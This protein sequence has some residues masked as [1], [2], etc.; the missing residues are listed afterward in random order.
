MQTSINPTPLTFGKLLGRAIS[1]YPTHRAILLRTAAIFYL[2]AAALSFL[3]AE[4]LATSFLLSLVFWPVDGIVSLSLITHCIDSLHGRPL[5]ISPA[6][7]RGLRRL[8]AYMG[9]SVA[10]LVVLSGVAFILAAPVWIGLLYSG[11]SLA[12]ILDAFSTPANPDQ[13]DIV[14]RVLGSALWGG[15]GLC[16]SGL[17]IPAV[18]FYLSTR[19]RFAE[20]ALMTEGTGPLESL[21]RSWS[22]SR[23]FVLRTLG[24]LLLIVIVMGLVGGVIG[25]ALN[26]AVDALAPTTDQSRMIGFSLAFSRLLSI[27]VMPFYVTAI[28]LYYFDLRVRKEKYNFGVVQE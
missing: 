19:W 13:V 23:G 2:P 22:L 6:V 16:L 9:L 24:Y 4:D 8:P 28:V 12:E 5:A 17:L 15:T 25:A 21:R 18:L 14:F 7:K 27:I 20:A 3:F 26:F 10:V 11:V 1:L